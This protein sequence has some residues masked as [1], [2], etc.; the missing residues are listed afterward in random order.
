MLFNTLY[1]SLLN[2]LAKNMSLQDIADKHNVNIKKIKTQ[3]KIGIKVEM[4]HTGSKKMAKV[5]AMDHLTEHPDYYT[6]LK[7]AGL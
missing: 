5:I 6:K 3:L 2:G 4:E 1:E 7:K